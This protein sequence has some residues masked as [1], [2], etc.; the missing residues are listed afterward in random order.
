[1]PFKSEA[2]RKYLWAN[3]PEIAR[4]WTDTY[5]SGIQAAHGGRIGFASGLSLVSSLRAMSDEELTKWNKEQGG[6]PNAEKILK[7]RAN[8]RVSGK[9]KDAGPK[10]FNLF[11]GMFNSTQEENSS[12][13]MKEFESLKR[14]KGMSEGEARHYLEN[15]RSE[16]PKAFEEEFNI[17]SYRDLSSA[18]DH[19]WD[20]AKVLDTSGIL[21]TTNASAFPNWEDIK[22]AGG[23]IE[24]FFFSPLNAAENKGS[25]ILP[26]KK[27]RTSDPYDEI[28][29][30]SERRIQEEPFSENYNY[31]K[32]T[33]LGIDNIEP[34]H[35]NIDT[36][37]WDETDRKNAIHNNA[38]NLMKQNYE[39][40]SLLERHNAAQREYNRVAPGANVT[41]WGDSGNITSAA[42]QGRRNE[43]WM[44][45]II[46]N[47]TMGIGKQDVKQ[48]LI[49][50]YGTVQQ[51]QNFADAIA[52]KTHSPHANYDYW[53]GQG[54]DRKDITADVTGMYTD[55]SS[56]IG[57]IGD[58][59]T[60][61]SSSASVDDGWGDV[62]GVS[63]I[64]RGGMVKDAPR[65]RYAEGGIVN[66]LPKG[67]W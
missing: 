29:Q 30:H 5:G 54:V 65:Y 49:N 66:L 13:L 36:M 12:P 41:P 21:R 1:M 14:E 51:Q 16:D 23:K 33:Y 8:T 34:Q 50:K 62:D 38:F 10:F 4:D 24:D 37:H 7:E 57:D 39:G 47:Y 67:A 2:Q 25:F 17:G 31:D 20:S 42:V 18:F 19:G 28:G 35:L 3:E 9:V 64:A 48:N 61:E 53:E 6:D 44:N 45:S 26:E 46:G 22:T 40:P 56:G 52:R 43:D 27:Y 63:Y 55:D 15:K 58:V 60:T 32:G 11:P 59:T